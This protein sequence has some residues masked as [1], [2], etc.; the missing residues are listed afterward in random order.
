MSRVFKN[1][2][3]ITV[4]SGIRTAPGRG[5]VVARTPHVAVNRVLSTWKEIVA[6]RRVERSGVLA[7][8]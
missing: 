4:Q 5:K 8:V 7:G 2:P 3:I 6:P 1:G